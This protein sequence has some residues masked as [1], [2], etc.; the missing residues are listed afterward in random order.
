MWAIGNFFLLQ[1]NAPVHNMTTGKLFLPKKT[2]HDHQVGSHTVLFRSV[3][4]RL[5]SVFK[6]KITFKLRLHL[7]ANAKLGM[8]KWEKCWCGLVA[9]SIHLCGE[10]SMNSQMLSFKARPHLYTNVNKACGTEANANECHTS[11]RASVPLVVC[12]LP[13]WVYIHISMIANVFF[14]WVPTPDG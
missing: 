9:H 2:K 12:W 13:K 7:R 1:E 3:P 5:F 4:I 10:C 6:S 8:Q 11:E 14:F